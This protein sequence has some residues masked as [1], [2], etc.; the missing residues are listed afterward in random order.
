VTVESN[1]WADPKV[2]RTWLKRLT[3]A[4]LILALV[5]LAIAWVLAA[6]PFGA[7]MAHI[8]HWRGNDKVKTFG[9]PAEWS[10]D[11]AALLRDRY[12]VE[13][14]SVAGC[15]PPV[16][17]MQ[18][19]EGYNRV[20]ES[21]LQQKYG[22]DIL[23]ECAAEVRANLKNAQNA[24]SSVEDAG[25]Y[26]AR[27]SVVHLPTDRASHF[28][29]NGLT[30]SDYIELKPD[31]TYREITQADVGV[32]P[33]KE[34]TWSQDQEGIL[35]F[36]SKTRCA[37]V[38]SSPLEVSLVRSKR[39]AGLPKLKEAIQAF[40]SSNAAAQFA[41]PDREPLILIEG[42]YDLEV[43]V[44][45]LLQR[46]FVSRAELEQLIAAIDQ[47][48]SNP[49]Q[50]NCQAIPMRYKDRVFLLWL[51][52]NTPS[53]RSLTEICR[54]IDKAKPED[55]VIHYDFMISEED[56]EK[57]GEGAVPLQVLPGN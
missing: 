57:R 10:D 7:V 25:D 17:L 28:Y 31:G 20:S 42:E 36:V 40:L 39:I 44:N 19:V 46:Q 54:D 5:V 51:N 3:L 32:L 43:E 15:T 47:F 4:R 22:K 48:L 14:N 30:W 13:L 16:S 6:W 33:T 8:D 50:R 23:E 2:K 41:V 9:L 12:G 49:E 56:F 1:E 29:A 53:S 45:Y 24:N 55:T 18:Y 37:D 26:R 27:T 38:I 34:G 11:Y 35:T 21:Y 52:C